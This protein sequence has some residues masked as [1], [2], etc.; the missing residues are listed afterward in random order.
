[1]QAC[2]ARPNASAKRSDDTKANIAIET[3]AP[4]HPTRVASSNS[5]RLCPRTSFL[6]GTFLLLLKR[7]NRNHDGFCWPGALRF[8]LAAL[9]DADHHYEARELGWAGCTRSSTTAIG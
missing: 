9:F 1:M 2:Q 7:R 3:I 8:R 5:P 4:R 6:R